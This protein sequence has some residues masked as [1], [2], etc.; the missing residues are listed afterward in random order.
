VKAAKKYA[1][2]KG[3]ETETPMAEEV[4]VGVFDAEPGKPGFTEKSVLL[5]ERRRVTSGAQTITV[6]VDQAP[7][8]AGI[9]PFNKRIDRNSDDNLV[10]PR[11]E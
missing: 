1:D 7:A 3:V 10:K 6:V 2:G 9:D 8:F 11:S 5:L 4:E